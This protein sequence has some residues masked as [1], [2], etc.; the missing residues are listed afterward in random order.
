M[1]RPPGLNRA[2]AR[3]KAGQCSAT[4]KVEVSTAGLLA[5]GALVSGVLVST[6]V[7]VWSPGLRLA[8][9]RVCLPQGARR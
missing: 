8:A 6:S 9:D 4:A 3:L 5:I 7:L 1:D 2:V